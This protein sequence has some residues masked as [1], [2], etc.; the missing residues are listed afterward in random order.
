MKSSLLSKSMKEILAN[1]MSNCI[2]VTIYYEN[3]KV[4]IS[5]GTILYKLIT[6]LMSK[7]QSIM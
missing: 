3:D 1:K 4:S 7:S 5:E 2:C 6:D